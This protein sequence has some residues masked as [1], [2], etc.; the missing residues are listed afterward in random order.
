MGI[1]VTLG[2]KA[3]NIEGAEMVVYS[4]AISKENP[5]LKAALEAASPA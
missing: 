1:P 4:A 2:Q 3:E 5:E